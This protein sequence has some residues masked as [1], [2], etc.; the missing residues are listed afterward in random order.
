MA[1]IRYCSVCSANIIFVT[2][3]IFMAINSNFLE[4]F[5]KNRLKKRIRSSKSMYLKT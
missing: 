3:S 4:Q 2:N 1:R 5:V